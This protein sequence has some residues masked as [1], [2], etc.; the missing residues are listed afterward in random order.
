MFTC[1]SKRHSA[2][3]SS[4]GVV[5]GLH[6]FTLEKY[7]LC[8]WISG[9]EHIE[10]GAF[11]VGGHQW[12]V[13]V[14]PEVVSVGDVYLGLRISLVSEKSDGVRCLFQMSLLDQSGKG[15]HLTKSFPVRCDV[16]FNV[17]G[18][19]RFSAHKVIL[20]ARSPVFRSMFVAS[21][22]RELVITSMEPRVFKSLLHFI[23]SDTLP[24][25]E[26]ALVVDGYAF[27]T[28]VSSTF[29]AN[30]LAAADEYD[31]K[32]L[33]SI[34]ES[35]LWRTNSFGRFAEILSVADRCNASALKHLCFKYAADNYA[36]LVK[37]DSF[38]YLRENCPLLLNEMDD[39][40]TE[41]KK[42][43][44]SSLHVIDSSMLKSEEDD[45]E[46][47]SV[48]IRR[49]ETG[50]HDWPLKNYSI[51]L[52]EIGVS[53]FIM[54]DDFTLCGHS[55]KIFFYPNGVNLESFNSG[56]GSLFFAPRDQECSIIPVEV[57][58][59]VYFLDQSG[60]GN[61]RVECLRKFMY[62]KR[63][64]MFGRANYIKRSNLE[65]PHY[66]KDDCLMIRCKITV[67]TFEIRSLPL[68]R[69]PE[70]NIVTDFGKLLDSRESAD[71]LFRVGDEMFWRH[72]WVLV[73]SCPVFQSRLLDCHQS[74]E[75]EIV[76]SHMEPRIFKAI[77]WFIYTG[78]LEDEDQNVVNYSCSSVSNSFMGKVL[79]AAHQFELTKLKR[80]CESRILGKLSAESVAYVL[81]LADIYHAT[82]LKAACLRFAAENLEEVVEVSGVRP[83]RNQRSQAGS[84]GTS[85]VETKVRSMGFVDRAAEAL[86]SMRLNMRRFMESSG[87]M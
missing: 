72:K 24:E 83:R 77:L 28:A 8:K 69:V 6:R 76:I 57:L 68:I 45:S 22:Q 49:V 12:V 9:E 64:H 25:D 54:S 21:D 38:N 67:F 51:L 53:K 40:V 48:T 29:G 17:R 66:L 31:I 71:V 3:P 87:R 10:S 4:T 61:H 11:T 43:G 23:Y 86:K 19:E 36:A 81:H 82:K 52:K 39:Y 46:S 30:L 20:S 35:H 26:R 60:K 47:A 63:G 84:T 75:E 79:A 50:Y 15:D 14:F 7:S 73:S 33:K 18:E 13:T 65:S 1:F 74:H 70:S 44:S 27:G 56:C 16:V 55:W 62:V 37:R 2:P 32:R 80:I 34:C 58:S 85:E 42:E 41:T 5:N 59:E 78:T